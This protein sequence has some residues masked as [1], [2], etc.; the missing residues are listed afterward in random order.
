MR[1]W[2]LVPEALVNRYYSDSRMPI[3]RVH[4]NVPSRRLAPFLDEVTERVGAVVRSG[5]WLNGTETATFQEAFSAYCGVPHCLGVGNGTD[6]LELALTAAG[7]RGGEVITVANAGGYTTTACRIVGATPVYVDVLRDTLLLD[8]N[9][10]DATL[11]PDTRAIVV[12]HL[13]GNV[14]DTQ[15][16]RKALASAGRNDVV[17]IEDCSQAHG[18]ALNGHAVGGDGDISVFSFYPTKNLGGLGDAGAVLSRDPTVQAQLAALHQYGW[19][20]R[21]DSTVPFGRNSRMDEIQAAVLNLALPYLDAWN[22]QRRAIV[23]RYADAT[24]G[25]GLHWVTETDGGGVAHLAVLRT[26]S[27]ERLRRHLDA[28]GIDSDV[29]YPKLD[30]EQTSQIGL[31]ARRGSLVNTMEARDEI[32]TVPCFPGMANDEVERVADALNSYAE[33]GS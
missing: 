20:S 28:A 32:T 11:S 7:T 29:H 23:R 24:A 17:V 6:G 8:P 2:S 5:M 13:F 4:V 12:T 19:T 25:S 27:R 16:V 14:A 10:L 31:P 26:R 22:D 18:A 21:Y 30:F 15:A 3:P 9:G 33:A 1:L